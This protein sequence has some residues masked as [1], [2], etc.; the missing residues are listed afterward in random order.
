MHIF[1]ETKAPKWCDRPSPRLYLPQAR[2]EKLAVDKYV[3]QATEM[4]PKVKINAGAKQAK[5]AQFIY[6]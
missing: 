1:F 2:G 3:C 6:K 4:A 5:Q